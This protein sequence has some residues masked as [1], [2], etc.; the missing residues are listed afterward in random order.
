[1]VLKELPVRLL[2]WLGKATCPHCD[3]PMS[4]TEFLCRDCRARADLR[5]GLC[6]DSIA[7]VQAF[8][9]GDYDSPLGSAVRQLKYRS[10]VDLAR[11]LGLA[12]AR[13]AASELRLGSASLLVPVPVHPLRLVERGYNQAALLT[14]VIARELGCHNEPLL[15][16][17]TR[18]TTQQAKL[19]A[20]ERSNNVHGAIRLRKRASRVPIVL[21]DDV[22]ATGSTIR[23]CLAAL[24]QSGADV[25]A[26]LVVARAGAKSVNF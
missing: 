2:D 17:R 6:P 19:A 21:V 12:M 23:A 24:R 15:L 10:R 20:D 25:T 16:Q 13:L 22:V 11:P 9:L 3:G 8:A 7:E 26:V 18:A 1:M 4:H 14:R 5:P